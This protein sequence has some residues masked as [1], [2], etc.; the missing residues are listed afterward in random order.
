VAEAV[1]AG[2]CQVRAGDRPWAPRGKE[3][4]GR[5]TAPG[6]E[7]EADRLSVGLFDQMS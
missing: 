3:K 1:A 7:I 4:A 6:P 5:L 2:G